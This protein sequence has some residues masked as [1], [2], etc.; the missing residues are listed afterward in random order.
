[1]AC[2]VDVVLDPGDSEGGPLDFYFESL[3]DS[4]ESFIAFLVSL[5]SLTSSSTKLI[6]K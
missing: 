3:I 2:I 5:S 1:M 6:F 4:E